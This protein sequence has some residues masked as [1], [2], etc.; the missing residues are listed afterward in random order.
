MI[1]GRVT[2]YHSGSFDGQV[3]QE[4]FGLPLGSSEAAETL[5]EDVSAANA[6][7]IDSYARPPRRNRSDAETL[8][9][10]VLRLG[11]ASSVEEPC[12]HPKRERQ[13]QSKNNLQLTWRRRRSSSARSGRLG[14]RPPN[15]RRCG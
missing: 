8:V 5:G 10:P 2:T 4:G 9:P 13:A 12:W 11:F 1:R 3:S 14:S 7:S 15:F 6:S